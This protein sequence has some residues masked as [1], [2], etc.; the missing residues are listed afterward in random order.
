MARI[1]DN[2]L[3]ATSAGEVNVMS[4]VSRTEYDARYVGEAAEL[5]EPKKRSFLDASENFLMREQTLELRR[6]KQASRQASHPRGLFRVIKSTELF[7]GLS[8]LNLK[9]GRETKRKRERARTKERKEGRNDDDDDD[10][11][12]EEVE[13]GGRGK[14]RPTEEK[15]GSG[16]G[17]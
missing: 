12:S 3:R 14:R 17:N 16:G 1:T 4:E 2:N 11:G 8:G 15:R 7:S 9:R 10:N 6:S 13:I 5:V